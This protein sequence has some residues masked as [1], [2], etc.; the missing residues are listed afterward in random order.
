MIGHFSFSRALPAHFIRFLFLFV[1][2]LRGYPRVST[3]ILVVNLFEPQVYD[4]LS[5]CTM[6]PP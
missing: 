4:S 5:C 3:I 1:S 6:R 2:A